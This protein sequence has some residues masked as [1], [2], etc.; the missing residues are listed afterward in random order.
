MAYDI[1]LASR[2]LRAIRGGERERREKASSDL[3]ASFEDALKAGDVEYRKSPYGG[4]TIQGNAGE[5]LEVTFRSDDISM[6]HTRGGPRAM[7][8][9]EAPLESVGLTYDDRDADWK[10]PGEVDALVTLAEAVASRLKAPA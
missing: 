8:E 7:S 6:R 3:K 2:I 4:T 9:R 10:G 5:S 1:D